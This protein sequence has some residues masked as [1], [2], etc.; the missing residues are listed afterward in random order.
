MGP[1]SGFGDCGARS[2]E[3]DHVSLSK[4]SIALVLAAIGAGTGS[5]AAQVRNDASSIAQAIRDGSID[6]ALRYRYEHV[7]QDGIAS[8]GN[9]AVLRTRLTFETARVHGFSLTL[10]VDDLRAIGA[11]GFNSTRNGKTDRPIVADPT[12][13]ELNEL[14]VRHDTPTG[15]EFS[16]GRQ[17]LTR[18]SRRFVGSLNWRQNEQTFEAVT[19]VGR[20]RG[21]IETSYAYVS[22]VNRIFGP[23]EGTP[24]ADF[25]GAIHL[26]DVKRTLDHGMQLWGYGYFLDLDT[27]A[28][29]STATLGIRVEGAYPISDRLRVPYFVDVARQQDHAHNPFD[30]AADYLLLESGLGWNEFSVLVGI[31]VL[32]GTGRGGEAFS[33]PLAGLHGRNGWADQF[34]V[35]PSGG[36]EDRYVKLGRT[37]G[38]G[39][40][41]VVY[42]DYSA[43]A[44]GS[45]YG[46]E[47]DVS[48]GWPIT[49]RYSLLIKAADYRADGF[50]TDTRKFWVMVSAGF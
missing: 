48:V 38:G 17:R 5:A 31:E 29:L 4:F 44:G 8:H 47:V 45:S 3:P 41:D 13:T 46:T 14:V 22:N 42:H 37:L 28:A 33:T 30:Y 23:K 40:L 25:G 19:A 12:A 24:P 7:D 21:G 16:L 1:R 50:A 36:L 9:A 10:E 6:L 43:S 49:E 26:I 15:L 32:E 27:A 2:F 20:S 39:R 11:D 34:V 18:S 35:T